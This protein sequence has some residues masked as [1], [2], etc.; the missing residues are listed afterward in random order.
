ML[1]LYRN[2]RKYR[3]DLKMSQDELAKR[4]GYTDRS[5]IAKI[6]KGQ[7]DLSQSKI[8]TFASIFGVSPG[9]LMGND[10]VQVFE[11]DPAPY[12]Q[13]FDQNMEDQ[14]K[15]LSEVIRMYVAFNEQDRQEVLTLMC[16]K[17]LK[18]KQ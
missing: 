18:Y 4:A 17:Y 8:R 12:R 10:G 3:K 2:I 16:M 6:E 11:V 5:S 7:V 13:L 15:G 1:E 9:E 14:A